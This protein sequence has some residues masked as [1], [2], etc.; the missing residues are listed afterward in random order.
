VPFLLALAI[1]ALAAQS[2]AATSNNIGAGEADGSVTFS[3]TGVPPVFAPCKAVDFTLV[4]GNSTATVVINAS[5]GGIGAALDGFAGKV[6]LNGNGH[7]YCE[8][9]SS[10]GG[11]LNL[12]V[13]TAN[14][15]NG[16]TFGCPSLTGGY[17]RVG[18]DVEAI[19]GGS[20]SVNSNPVP[21]MFIF[22][23]EFNPTGGSGLSQ[24][25]LA[26]PIT[27]ADFKG[28]FVVAPA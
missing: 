8:G 13:P 2:A 27:T 26:G 4:N 25:G 6:Q 14:G 12:S 20:C 1:S 22:R 3:G 17:T 28:A 10:G 7:G 15:P 5:T 18:P 9:T 16:S 24:P 21:A 23:G 19:L 11:S